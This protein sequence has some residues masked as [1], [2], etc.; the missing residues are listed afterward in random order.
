MSDKQTYTEL[1]E[2]LKGGQKEILKLW[3]QQLNETESRIKTIY[4]DEDLK[5]TCSDI[6]N[7]FI[8][9]TSTGSDVDS[10]NYSNIRTTLK[11]MSETGAIKG[12]TPS[13]TAFFIFTLKDAMLPLIQSKLKGEKLIEKIG[14][15]NRQID[16]LGMMTFES[17]VSSKEKLV[18][19]QSQAMLELSAPVVKVW[20]KILMVP[21][22]GMLDSARTQQVMETLLTRIEE[23]QSKV[24]ILDISG[25]PTVDSLVAKH[26]IR[27]VS[28]TKLMGAECIIT[29]IN[30]RISQTMIQLGIDLS[31]IT[32]KTTMADGLAI[33][34]SM[35]S[36]KITNK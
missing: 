28:A 26:L 1:A 3:V 31:G 9:A 19:D 22:I 14:I 17:Y 5:R 7:E 4:G 25:I 36:L 12:L 10:Q 29:G 15:V 20:D 30:A 2:V 11:K 34:L 27:T 35:T 24:A 16:R 32:T 6:L 21:L 18:K 13:E 23:T 33:A 8:K